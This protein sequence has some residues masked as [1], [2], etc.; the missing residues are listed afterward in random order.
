LITTTT[1]TVS[2]AGTA[3][4]IQIDPNAAEAT[5]AE[6]APAIA[7]ACRAATMTPVALRVAAARS[8]R[9]ALRR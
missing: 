4:T 8:G 7:P 5:P 9:P 1:P 3:R 2:T 6:S